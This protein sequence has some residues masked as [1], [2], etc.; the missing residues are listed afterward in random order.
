MRVFD[1]LSLSIRSLRLYSLR[2]LL[3]ILGVVIGTA[4]VLDVVSVAE[5]A[6]AEVSKQI[7]SLGSHL[8]LVVPGAQPDQGVRQQAGSMLTL[9]A[10][11]ARALAQEIPGVVFAAP[12]IDA[13]MTAVSGNLNWSTLIAGIT[14]DYFQAR[15]WALAE[16]E[17]LNVEHLSR[18]AKVGVIG[19][20]VARELFPGGDSIGRLIR[21][22]RTSYVVIGVL[23]EKGQDFAGRDQD[24]V[25][26]IPLTSAKIFTLGRSHANPDTV[27]SILVKA[28]SAASMT[29][30]EPLIARIL[31]QRHKLP[32]R[33]RDDFQIQNLVQVVQ[34]R[35]KVYRQF[36]LLVS[37][38]AGISLVVGGIG[39]MNVMLVTVAE[40]TT[41]IGIRLVVGACPG[42]IRNQFLLEASLLC[43]IGGLLGLA[44][45]YATAR[46]FADALGWTIEFS[47]MLATVA[48]GC[49][50]LIGLVFGLIPAERAARLDPVVALRS[51]Q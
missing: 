32:E 18:A 20:T 5:G 36:T 47:P 43:T 22:G 28:D 31:R 45:G 8:L 9:T 44:F 38:L 23:A 14:P 11:D 41:E 27:H 37:M 7:S 10:A 17:W 4:A 12:F 29:E 35:D 3:A 6:R 50:A 34:T 21:V 1:Y 46:V 24:D 33:K 39:V 19:N 51:G 2:S 16:G 40:R 30:A 13:Q 42:D 15:G 26:F 49:A 25:V 48:V